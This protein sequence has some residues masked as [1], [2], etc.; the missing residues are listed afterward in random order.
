VLL[1]S[2]DTELLRD[3]HL[4]FPADLSYKE[5]KGIQSRFTLG[6]QDA[7]VSFTVFSQV[8][9]DILL[10]GVDDLGM[11]HAFIETLDLV[12]VHGDETGL[13]VDVLKGLLVQKYGLHQLEE[14]VW[15]KF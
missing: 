4:L 15:V 11:S 6:A 13:G 10:E 8:A 5:D 9:D 12:L 3:L 2:K 1:D 14:T 7:V